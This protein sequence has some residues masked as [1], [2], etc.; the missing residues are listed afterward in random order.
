[1]AE[2]DRGQGKAEKP[3]C[4]FYHLL[5]Q[6]VTAGRETVKEMALQKR[7]SPNNNWK[8]SKT[9]KGTG[10]RHSR[11]LTSLAEDSKPGRVLET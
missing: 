5:L 11:R 6:K 8:V 1:M 3:G 7:R 10:K 9:P 2:L 4:R